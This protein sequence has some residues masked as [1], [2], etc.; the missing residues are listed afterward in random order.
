MHSSM[1][2]FGHKLFSSIRAS[3]NYDAY[4]EH[5]SDLFAQAHKHVLHDKAILSVFKSCVEHLQQ[6]SGSVA[7][8]DAIVDQVHLILLTKVLN[9]VNNDFLI[10]I[11]QLDKIESNKGTGA[12]LLLRDKLKAAAGDTHSKIPKI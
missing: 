5:G 10:N 8:E 3:L 9:T 1:L 12:N 7:V 6:S 4:I 2:P 11:S